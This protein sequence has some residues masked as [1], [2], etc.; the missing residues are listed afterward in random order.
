MLPRERG[1]PPGLRLCVPGSYSP[2]HDNAEVCEVK[3]MERHSTL[4][5]MTCGLSAEDAAPFCDKIRRPG[6]IAEFDA[7]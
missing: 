6:S 4:R 3:I 2:H 7:R 5:T 1:F